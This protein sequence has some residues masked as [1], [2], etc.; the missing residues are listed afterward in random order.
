MNGWDYYKSIDSGA[1]KAIVFSYALEENRK[2]A[3]FW[4]QASFSKSELYSVQFSFKSHQLYNS[5]IHQLEALK[6]TKVD[7]EIHSN[8]ITLTYADKKYFYMLSTV[9]KQNIIPFT[10][11]IQKNNNQ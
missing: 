11:E 10:L 6:V 5:I 8:T 2:A 1:Y 9:S 7:Q 3:R 4:Y